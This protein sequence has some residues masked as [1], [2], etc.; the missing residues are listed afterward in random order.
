[1]IDVLSDVNFR[2]NGKLD[3]TPKVVHHDRM[4]PIVQR[5]PPDL[6]WVFEQSRTCERQRAKNKSATSAEQMKEVFDRLKLLENES[7]QINKYR[8]RHDKNKK[9]AVPP[10]AVDDSPQDPKTSPKVQRKRGRPRKNLQTS[11]TRNSSDQRQLP[12]RRSE[13]LKNQQQ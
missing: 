9:K 1:M 4:K 10:L 12:V 8:K 13:R 6:K 7:R 3:N 5:E 2:V 11:P